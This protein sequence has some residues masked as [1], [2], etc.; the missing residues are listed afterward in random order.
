MQNHTKRKVNWK[1]VYLV[2]IS[3]VAVVSVIGNYYQ[4]RNYGKASRLNESYTKELETELVELNTVDI[5][6]DTYTVQQVK[7]KYLELQEQYELLYK[8]GE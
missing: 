3:L 2:F 4:D 6:G 1:N 7:D 8:S 5:H